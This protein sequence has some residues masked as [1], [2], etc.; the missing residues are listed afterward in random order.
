M[1]NIM[2]LFIFPLHV[3]AIFTQDLLH[4]N[5]KNRRE[6]FMLF[7]GFSVSKYVLNFLS[8]KIY[9]TLFHIVCIKHNAYYGW[10]YLT[11]VLSS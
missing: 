2:S 7:S 5:G 6:V 10:H 4:G 9:K 1:P 8:K 11:K 3:N